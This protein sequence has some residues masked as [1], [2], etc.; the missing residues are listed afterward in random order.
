MPLSKTCVGRQQTCWVGYSLPTPPSSDRC[1]EGVE[2]PRGVVV[3]Q[4]NLSGHSLPAHGAHTDVGVQHVSQHV[5][6]VGM[7]PDLTGDQQG[8]GL[9]Y[10]IHLLSR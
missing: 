2:G 6:H 10:G 8:G 1:P 4:Y 9:V 3:Q 7:L 5:E